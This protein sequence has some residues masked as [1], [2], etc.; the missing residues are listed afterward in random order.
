M[1]QDLPAVQQW[2]AGALEA[3]LLSDQE[4][5]VLLTFARLADILVQ[6][7][8]FPPDYVAPPPALANP[9]TVRWRTFELS[10]DAMIRDF[11]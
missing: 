5:S 8:D 4:R 9:A 3:G 1:P 6:V 11:Q 10:R 7:D 2:V